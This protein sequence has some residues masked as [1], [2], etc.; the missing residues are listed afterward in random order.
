MYLNETLNFSH[1]IKEEMFKA[2]KG[3]GIIEK[4]NSKLPQDSFV[5]IQKAYVRL[6]LEFGYIIYDQPNDESFIQK[7]RRK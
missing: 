1:Q 2:M 5:T 4:R 7:N 3:I 6:H